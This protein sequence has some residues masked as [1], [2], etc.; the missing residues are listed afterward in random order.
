MF[1][2]ADTSEPNVHPTDPPEL[3][4]PDDDQPRSLLTTLQPQV[5]ALALFRI[6]R[7][8]AYKGA[9]KAAFV[10]AFEFALFAQAL[11]DNEASFF[12][13]SALRG[14][15]EDLI[16]LKFLRQLSKKDRDEMVLSR[17][18]QLVSVAVTRQT[19]F[20][21]HRRPFQSVFSFKNSE[22]LG[23]DT[24]ERMKAIGKRTGLWSDKLTL[25][26]VEQ[27]AKTI[28]MEDIYQFF[29]SITSEVV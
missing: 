24:R 21:G 16:V 5:T 11:E 15:C 7:E 1:R 2:M 28:E 27:M 25:P 14:I 23:T 4:D 12:T 3:D 26:S 17:M 9:L 29:Y 8:G 18:M 10:K 13:A 19:A 22:D 6:G 20:F